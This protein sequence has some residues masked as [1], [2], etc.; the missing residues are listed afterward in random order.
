[1]MYH[2]PLCPSIEMMFGKSGI[3]ASSLCTMPFSPIGRLNCLSIKARCTCSVWCNKLSHIHWSIWHHCKGPFDI[4]D[5]R[6]SNLVCI[7][8]VPYYVYKWYSNINVNVSLISVTYTPV[9][10]DYGIMVYCFTF[11]FIYTHSEELCI[12][13]KM[14]IKTIQI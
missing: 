11:M 10:V 13:S 4:I 7:Y 12:H 1:M 5:I 3:Y 2:W 14:T 9:V 6:L 8:L